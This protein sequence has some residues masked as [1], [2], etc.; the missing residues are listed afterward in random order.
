[1]AHTILLVDWH[2]ESRDIYGTLLQHHGFATLQAA[3]GT[4]GLRL[5]RLHRPDL[6]LVDLFVPWMDGLAIVRQLRDH[7]DT[8]RVPL[9][10]LTSYADDTHMSELRAAAEHCFAKP[11]WPSELLAAVRLLLGFSPAPAPGSRPAANHLTR[12]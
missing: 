2:E 6:I 12:P 9:I 8:A 1:M 5:A 3:D 11:C 10:L 4:E 7:D